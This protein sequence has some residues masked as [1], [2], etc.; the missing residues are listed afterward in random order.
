[1]PEKRSVRSVFCVAKKTVL[2]FAN[3]VI[4]KPVTE[5]ARLS[6]LNTNLLFVQKSQRLHMFAMVVP[7][8]EIAIYNMLFT[9]LSRLM[10]LLMI[11]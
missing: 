11:C 5:T 9:L 2:S 8:L 4:A 1:V 3:F 6:A 10:I 7:N